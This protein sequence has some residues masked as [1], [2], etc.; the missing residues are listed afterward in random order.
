M[1]THTAADAMGVSDFIGRL[2]PGKVAD[3]V[4]L[5][6]DRSNPYATVTSAR[7]QDVRAVF[8]G[9]ALYYGDVSIFDASIARNAFC[10]EL[11]VCGTAKTL[12]IRDAGEDATSLDKAQWPFFTLSEM[13]TYLQ[14]VLKPV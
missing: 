11:D 13:Q 9:G 8:I 10:E 4:V 12:C 2:S 1:A 5:Q 3:V 14:N 6:G 7:P